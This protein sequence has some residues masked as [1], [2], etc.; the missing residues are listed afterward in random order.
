[1]S[2]QT[3]GTVALLTQLSRSVYRRC[4]EA[5]MGPRLKHFVALSHLRELGPVTQ[6]TLG[7]V[8]CVDSNN[9]V[10]LL[11]ELEASGLVE[12]R[13]DPEDRRRHIVEITDDGRRVLDET[14]RAM[15]SVEDD[16]LAALDPEQRDA[17]HDLLYQAVHGDGGTAGAA[18]G[19]AA[20]DQ[21]A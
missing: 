13:R 11:N 5:G 21:P 8:F 1:M 19:L 4:T 2:P 16:L 12:R 14:Q 15:G 20:S 18:R 17:L 6:Q 10:L 3:P 7:G 9:L